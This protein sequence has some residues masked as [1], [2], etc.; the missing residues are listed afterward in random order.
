MPL[1]TRL[2]RLIAPWTLLLLLSMPLRAEE[3]DPLKRMWPEVYKS[4]RK[5]WVDYN[6]AGDSLSRVD[7]EKGK[8]EIQVL[9]PIPE[10][11]F[12]FSVVTR[13]SDLDAAQWTTVRAAAQEKISKQVERMLSK[14]EPG[15]PPMLNEQI[16][17][18]DD[19]FLVEAKHATRYTH[20]HLIPQMVV[21]EKPVEGTD[22]I[23]RIRIRVQ[24]ELVPDHMLI[25]ARRY[26]KQVM[27][28]ARQFDLDP[29]LIY[30]VIHSES[31]FDPMS[32]SK[33]G[34]IG[35]MQLM[36]EAAAEADK[37]IRKAKKERKITPEYLYDPAN[38]IR[39]GAA[40]LHLLQVTYFSKVTNRDH[41]G[42]LCVAAYNCG[43][44]YIKKHVVLNKNIDALTGEQ[45]L[46]L[47]LP[48]VPRETRYYVP[49]VLERMS[50]YQDI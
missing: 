49:R 46:K 37:F 24:F 38:N 20:D 39:L 10:S 48:H 42:A 32:T 44:F 25:R 31:Y 9:V 36:P 30:A 8:F 35:L 43:P 41:R 18:P 5:E 13:F 17:D 26:K 15:M 4:T 40:Y 11:L 50:L 45:L 3:T 33:V 47:L 23:R 2:A 34:A 22:R 29:A 16:L 28:S 27:E 21:E 1:I 14:A 7:F 6:K 19:K 12:D